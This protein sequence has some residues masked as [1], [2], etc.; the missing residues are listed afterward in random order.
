M[1]S[2]VAGADLVCVLGGDGTMLRAA[3]IAPPGMLVV[4][5][6]TDPMR[7][8]GARSGGDDPRGPPRAAT[9]H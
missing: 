4:G 5:I 9:L 1:P 3:R 8:F 7:S 6:N 2:D